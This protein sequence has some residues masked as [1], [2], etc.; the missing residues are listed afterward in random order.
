YRDPI[1]EIIRIGQKPF[2]VI[3]V[4]DPG[5]D[6]SRLGTAAGQRSAD[7]AVFIPLTTVRERW[8]ERNVRRTAG[9]MDIEEVE[10]H[11]LIVR[12]KRIEDVLPTTEAIKSLLKR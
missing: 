8:G 4:L 6:V 9:S 3:G 10:I 7:Q 11:D 5:P 2:R 12:T 1:G